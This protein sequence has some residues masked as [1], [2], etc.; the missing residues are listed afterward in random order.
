VQDLKKRGID[1]AAV[2]STMERDEVR[3]VFERVMNDEVRLLY[4]SL[5][6]FFFFT[7]ITRPWGS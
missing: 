6:F 2:D 5:L 7:D 1:A 4:V 3:A